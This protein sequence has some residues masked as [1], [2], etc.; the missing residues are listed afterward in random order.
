MGRPSCPDLMG[1]PLSSSGAEQSGDCQWLWL[2]RRWPRLRRIQRRRVQQ[3]RRIQWRWRWLPWKQGQQRGRL[4][5][6]IPGERC[7]WLREQQLRLQQQE[8]RQI[9][10]WEQGQLLSRADHPNFHQHLAQA[11][12]GVEAS[13]TPKSV[14]PASCNPPDLPPNRPH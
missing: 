7:R 13:Y 10:K 8:Q 3:R 14:A 5:R 1:L 11:H 4:W 6:W 2:R 9:R 12:P